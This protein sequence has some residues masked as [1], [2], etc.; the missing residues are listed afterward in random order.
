M[1]MDPKLSIRLRQWP[2]L[3]Q[4]PVVTPNLSKIP[5]QIKRY[6]RAQPAKQALS[7]L[8]GEIERAPAAIRPYFRFFS[9]GGYEKIPLAG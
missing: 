3:M 4:F 2:K 8:R 7:G 9:F 5:D 1:N 6:I